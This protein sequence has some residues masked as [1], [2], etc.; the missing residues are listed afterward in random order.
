M[1][2]PMVRGRTFADA[3]DLGAPPV[4]IVNQTLARRHF[5]DGEAVGGAVTVDE[6]RMEIVGVVA[7]VAPLF[8]GEV[9]AAEIYYPKRQ[10]PRGATFF[11]VRSAIPPA[12]LERQV[13]E[14]AERD[15]PQVA[16]SGFG[17]LDERASGQLVSPRFSLALMGLFALVALVLAA[18]GVYGVTAYGVAT[19]TRELGLRVAL[20]A[21]PGALAR[22]IVA[23]VLALAGIGLAL[24]VGMAL[25]AGRL[26]ASQL[27]GVSS[28][29]LPTYVV[30]AGV[31]LTV[32]GVASSLAARRAARLDLVQA[33]RV[34]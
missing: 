24:G 7:D 17:S 27:H 2:I 16:L 25:A 12:S 13:L 5:R 22:S 34:Q 32:A 23:S 8:R 1:G 10:V 11:V 18:V 20:G 21:A 29:D 19:R 3:D 14:R 30:V 33:L 9:P 6:R 28:S 15:H 26:L 4:A 31:V